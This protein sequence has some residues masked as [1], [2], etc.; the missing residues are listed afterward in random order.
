MTLIEVLGTLSV[1]LVVAT[2]AA[3]ILGTITEVG[4]RSSD[5]REA[6]ASVVRLAKLFRD[7][8]IAASNVT[9]QEKGWPL[10]L[11]RGDDTVKYDWEPNESSIARSVYRNEQRAVIDHFRG[12]S[13]FQP[14]VDV[15]EDRVALIL[16]EGQTFLPWGV[17]VARK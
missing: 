17:E 7:D 6:R 4:V 2:A 13:R 8:V 9:Q 1:L 5:A 14:R 15:S 3:G 11:V 16:R 12:S 10:E